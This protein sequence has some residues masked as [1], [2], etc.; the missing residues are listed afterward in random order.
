[1]GRYD[2]DEEV[3]EK[4]G[5]SL[6]TVYRNKKT[7]KIEREDYYI[8]RYVQQG[9]GSVVYFERPA[10]S[11]NI[12]NGQ[13]EAIGR[14]DKTKPEG[15][16]FIAG[17]PHIEWNPPETQDQ[18]IAKENAALKAELAALKAEQNSKSAMKTM[19]TKKDQGA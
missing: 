18:K 16:R 6:Q 10:G 1:M 11:G 15:K 13:G 3:E 7:G 9:G 12:W 2:K 5:F 4:K 17:E 8:A 14:W 19:A